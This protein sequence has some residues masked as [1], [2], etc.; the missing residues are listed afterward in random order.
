MDFS[1]LVHISGKAG[2]FEILNQRQDGLIA[3]SLLDKKSNFVSSRIHQFTLLD[4]ISIYTNEDSEPLIDVFEKM[5]AL[6]ETAPVPGPKEDQTVLKTYFE[7]VL[8]DYDKDQ[9]HISDIKKVV[10]WFAMLEEMDLAKI[11]TEKKSKSK[12]KN[13]EEQNGS[14]N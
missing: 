6:K 10:K 9:V 3:K 13:E 14:N 2:L 5:L 8:P 12:N 11:I 7:K 1:K 4:N